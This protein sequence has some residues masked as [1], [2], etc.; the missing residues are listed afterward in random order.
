M[1][2]QR[3]VAVPGLSSS[4]EYGYAQVVVAGDLIFVAGQTGTDEQ[5][6]LVSP[7]FVPQARK[8]FENIERAL[9]A[10]GATRRNI[11]AMTV[12]ITDWRHGRDF[13][14]VRS[15]FL[16]EHLATSALIGISQLAYPGALVEVQCTAARSS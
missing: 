8:T 5:G 4:R 15:E 10:V 13:C 11:V 1:T 3:T 14:A 2:I 6:Q 9:Q 16:G 12:F 7:D